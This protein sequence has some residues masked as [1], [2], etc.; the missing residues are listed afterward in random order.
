MNLLVAGTI[1]ILNVTTGDTRISFD[2]DEP[3]E[4]ER[5]KAVVEDMLKRGYCL[6]VIV[7]D[8]MERVVE[9]D[10][11]K[12]EYIVES[13]ETA[14][15]DSKKGKK[16]RT[17]KIRVKRSAKDHGAVAVG[18]TAGGGLGCFYHGLRK[19]MIQKEV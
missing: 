2:S 3:Q 1:A 9:F 11:K 17:G 5:A 16:A 10:S 18:Q 13:N 6:S 15:V 14:P 8:K 12:N 7:G 4:I 19:S